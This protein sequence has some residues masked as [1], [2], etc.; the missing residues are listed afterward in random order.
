[1]KKKQ[2]KTQT[3]LKKQWEIKTKKKPKNQ[4]K[5]HKPIIKEI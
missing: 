4:K 3:N 1:M 2:G 5:K